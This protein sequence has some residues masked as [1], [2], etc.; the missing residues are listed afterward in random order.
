MRSYRPG[1]PLNLR[2]A[3]HNQTY[4]PVYHGA[5]ATGT[6]IK[7]W[8]DA[9][10]TYRL[11]SASHRPRCPR[12]GSHRP[13][14]TGRRPLS[15][16]AVSAE[17]GTILGASPSGKRRGRVQWGLRFLSLMMLISA[18]RSRCAVARSQGFAA[19]PA[20]LQLIQC[21]ALLSSRMSYS[22][23]AITLARSLASTFSCNFRDSVLEKTTF[24]PIA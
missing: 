23:L 18:W 13:T 21:K 3:I 8:S 10:D 15:G 22:Q 24:S 16:P 7:A 5:T 6:A 19:P 17:T 2:P 14:I 4:A 11:N 9:E 12:P 20:R 1:P